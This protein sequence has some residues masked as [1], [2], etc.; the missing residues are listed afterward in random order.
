MYK[1][2]LLQTGGQVL[3]GV[4]Y[5]PEEVRHPEYEANGRHDTA[6]G[7]R[8]VLSLQAADTKKNG[9]GGEQL[10]ATTA[11]AGEKSGGV[12]SGGRPNANASFVRANQEKIVICLTAAVSLGLVG[13]LVIVI[14]RMFRSYR[15]R[16]LHHRQQ[17]Q[18]GS[19]L[20]LSSM[21]SGHS[22]VDLDNTSLEE[23]E[24]TDGLDPDRHG[25][26]QR[27]P[28]YEMQ[29]P[30]AASLE[31][32]LYLEA[33]E[34]RRLPSGEAVGS[35]YGTVGRHQR[36]LPP[37]GILKNSRSITADCIMLPLPGSP[38]SDRGVNYSAS[39][40]ERQ[41]FPSRL[42]SAPD[43]T[44]IALARCD[45]ITRILSPCQD[46]SRLAAPQA[47]WPGEAG[48]RVGLVAALDQ[49]SFREVP[50]GGAGDRPVAAA[51]CEDGQD[52][53]FML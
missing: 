25:G 39:S 41:N 30:P 48:D 47:S 14:G 38:L 12:G 20:V 3:S 44:D 9:P 27:R 51:G 49:L 13:V 17:Q 21:A 24:L 8:D 5:L 1:V 23:M 4:K 19:S 42:D 31:A 35:L 26:S 52:Q 45:V 10:P 32:V 53:L 40:W 50:L 46:H 37:K 11:A 15:H 22:T 2:Y 34:A 29:S 33:P 43:G 18:Q 28:S 36:R 16:L 6:A 7:H